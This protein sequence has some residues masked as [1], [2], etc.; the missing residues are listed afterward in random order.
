MQLADRLFVPDERWGFEFRE[1]EPIRANPYLDQEPVWQEPPL[2]E[3][4]VDLLQA[5]QEAEAKR[6][7]R[8]RYMITMLA[9]ATL[10]P[11]MF[12]LL[13]VAAW[14][15]FQWF[16]RPNLNKQRIDQLQH[17]YRKVRD[18]A[19]AQYQVAVQNWK[20]AVAAYDEAERRR[21][22]T[23]VSWYPIRLVS[24]PSRV[25]VFGGTPEGWASLLATA[26]GSLLG[27]RQDLVLLDFTE[28]DVGGGLAALTAVRGIP[29]NR[30]ALPNELH[31]IDL[32]A[33][34]STDECAELLAEAVHGL[35]QSTNHADARALHADLLNA[36]LQ[37]LSGPL[38]FTRIAAGLAVLQ[39]AYEPSGGGPLHS[40]EVERLSAYAGT[41][42]QSE[43]TLKELRFLSNTLHL[44]AVDGGARRMASDGTEPGT[45]YDSPWNLRGLTI[46]ATFDNNRR[47]K[48]F[49]DH[50]LAQELVRALSN[51]EPQGVV[52]VAGADHLGL[53]TLEAITKYARR[54]DVRLVLLIEHLRGELQQLMGGTDSATFLM[55]LRNHQEATTAADYIGRGFR[56]TLSQIT[57]QVG[58][59]LVTGGAESWGVQHQEGE[60]WGSSWSTSRGPDGTTKSGG[61]HHST[62]E[63]WS[64]SW[65]E[66]RKW[67]TA[68]SE[69]VGRTMSRVYE[70]MVEPTT[71]QS[72][73]TT[74]FILVETG[75]AGRRIIAGDCNPGIALLDNVSDRPWP[76]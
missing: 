27:A 62:S 20:Q 64:R 71:L 58:R 26:G 50:V 53:Q 52:V 30:I 11:L 4:L 5:Q 19:F 25:D 42:G 34:A 61:G 49:T 63:S 72:L 2:P 12:I 33:T 54:A 55:C 1:P 14:F 31:R 70:Y 60:S 56:F 44:L 16:I 32:L 13:P 43:F 67:A 68:D 8:I 35:R 29:V 51:R 57:E 15:G 46:V 17:E 23:A 75:P 22:E 9:C 73:P 40:A 21:W 47:R 10:P 24:A 3:E 48:E 6:K 28:H 38:S 41:L 66:T 69:T 45:G 18:T 37:R 7:D 65:Q 74:A 76:S 59:T 36:V 39:G